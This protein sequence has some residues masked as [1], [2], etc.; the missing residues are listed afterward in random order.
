MT[1]VANT[2]AF[3]A[4]LFSECP[5]GF[6]EARLL[7]DK[8]GGTL[9]E[10]QWYASAAEFGADLDRLQ[11]ISKESNAAIYFGVLP[12]RDRGKGKSEDAAPART[13]WTDIDYKDFAPEGEPAARASLARF[14]LAP[15]IVVASGHGLHSYWLLREDAEASELSELSKA[16]AVAV[17]GDHTSDAARILRLPGSF[18]RKDPANPILVVI[19][20]LDTSWTFNPSDI[21]EA[22]ATVGPR[23]PP[24]RPPPRT[25]ELG[26]PPH[27]YAEPMRPALSILLSTNPRCR[28]LFN[29]TGKPGIGSD[30]QTTD[31][32]SSGYDFSVCSELIRRGIT[33]PVDLGRALWNRPDRSARDKGPA[34][35]E[36]TVNQAL[37]RVEAA[38][39]QQAGDITAATDFVVEKARLFNSVPARYEITIEGKV[40]RL[41]SDQLRSVQKFGLVFLDVLHRMPL[42]PSAD[43]WRLF[44]NDLMA[45]TEK[46]DMPPDA[47]EYG[48]IKEE[49]ARIIQSMPAGDTVADLDQGK[50][51]RLENG[52]VAFK[53][54]TISA[55]LKE[56][57]PDAELGDVSLILHDMG[58]QS[59]PHR[60]GDSVVRLWSLL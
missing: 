20:K 46:V 47:S 51:V 33:D 48:S 28:S 58:Y 14:P 22:A 16:I 42:M 27:A 40:L 21:R 23:R 41:D 30:G 10:R 36:R 53:R 19:E 55:L 49:V 6:I 13:L 11:G 1:S 44:V 52:R 50:G 60:V 8:K 56:A 12:R 25:I 38:K 43:D 31:T 17:G 32:S 2:K 57:H 9:V 24:K 7:E 37:S 5:P 59:R 15:S 54:K 45:R 26:A 29:G 34:Y 3:L 35:I 4:A 39:A 18:N